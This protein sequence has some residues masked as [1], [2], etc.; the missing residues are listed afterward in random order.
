MQTA[1]AIPTFA[2]AKI[3]P[4]RPRA[5]LVE[6]PELER[7]LAAALQHSR[8]TLLVAPA[9][10]GK[11]AALTRQIRLL[12]EGCA[13]AWVSADED[14]QLERFLACLTAALE[15]HD[16][17]WRVAPEALATLA[18]AERGLRHVAGEL[19]NALAASEAS[20]GL[21]VIDDA[22]RIADRRVF[23]LLQLVIERL[24]ARWSVA[25]AS[26]VE[27]PL[28]L[29]RWRGAGELTEFRQYDLRFS[30]ADVAALLAD[31]PPALRA[32]SANELLARTDGWA[33]GLRLSLSVR[34]A[35]SA[36][37]AR[38]ASLTQRHL[39]D[40]LAAEVFDTLPSDLQRFLLRVSVLSELSASRCAAVAQEAR[41][42]QFLEEIERRGLFAS[43]LDAS[44]ELTLRLHDLFREFLEDRLQR[45]HAEDVPSLLARA[46]Q[47][48]DD[49]RRR[50]L[51]LLR[52]DQPA[53]AEGALLQAAPRLLA[54]GGGGTLRNL[55]EQ[56]PEE[57]RARSPGLAFARGLIAWPRFEWS[58]MQR[59]LCQA[60]DGF[61]DVGQPALAQQAFALASVALTALNRLDEAATR[62]AQARAHPMGAD[63]E[64]LCELMSYWH[65]GA[66][67]PAEAPAR[68]LARMVELLAGQPPEIWNRCA[69]HFLFIG[70]PGMRRAMLDWTRGAQAV[71]GESHAHLQAAAHA[72]DAWLVLWEGRVDE[73][74]A[75]LREAKEEDRWL[76]QPGHLRM[77]LLALQGA[78]AAGQ[79]DRDGCRA[80][81]QA[82]LDDVSRDADRAATW[83]GLYLYQCIRMSDGMQDLAWA[84]ELWEALQAQPTAREW[85]L[86]QPARA[87]LAARRLLRAGHAQAA[88]EALRPWADRVD[89]FDMISAAADLRLTLADA[90]LACGDPAAAWRALGPVLQQAL[91]SGETMPLRMVGAAVLGRLAGARWPQGTPAPQL[92]L[93]DKAAER[94]DDVAS[95]GA[96]AAAGPEGLTAREL[97]ICGRIAAGDSNKL[98]ARAFELSPHTVKR[99]VANIL[100][101]LALASRGQVAAWYLGQARA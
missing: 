91:E 57:R 75:L 33:A 8:L 66:S 5:G 26:R 101:K 78:I 58:E 85:P 21:I 1:P 3:Q 12:P 63:T 29:A 23:E 60:G 87:T 90:E 32:T 7:T 53:A 71:A 62:L 95:A 82:M 67:G 4:P 10:F 86:M 100:D 59:S 43:V 73:A 81:A 96:P 65:A 46:A 11:T 34:P 77:A 48:E 25:I 74:A 94:R 2:L 30:E 15:P 50:V 68:H 47:V 27:P 35:A 79:G 22:H 88:A 14:D 37:G 51:L 84:D 44:D 19:V 72:L 42:V 28:A 13:L 38:N 80:A 89:A 40:Y 49:F 9:G 20:Q 70:R 64:A 24:P 16:L 31:A 54:A 39:F 97:Q 99:H 41:A 55:I 56:F 18:Q 6:R 17:P 92:A 76:G 93:L 36:G 52:A 98:I 45:E 83:R 61:V 69:P